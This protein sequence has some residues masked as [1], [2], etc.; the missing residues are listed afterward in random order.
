MATTDQE[1]P[2]L[3]LPARDIPIPTSVSPEAQAAMAMAPLPAPDLPAPTDHGSWRAMIAAQDAA[4]AQM[5]GGRAADAPVVTTELDVR[6][7]HVYEIVPT[8]LAGRDRR[9]YLEIHGGAFVFGG[10]ECCRVMSIGAATRFG[11]RVWAVDYRMPPDHPFPAGLDD[12]LTAYRALLDDHDPAEIIVG[13]ASAGGNLAAALVLLARDEGLPMP[14][15]VVLMTPGVDLTASDDSLQ[16]NLGLDP[17]LPGGSTPTFG[18]YAGDRDLTDPYVSPLFGDFAPGFPP[19]ILT[20]GT[21]DRLLSDTVRMHRALR[22]AGIPADLHVTEAAGH[23]GFLG[24]AP[25]DHEIE[26]ELRLFAESHWP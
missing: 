20:T 22:R 8:D 1:R 13:G 18:M 10:G 14:A 23:G 19:T 12:C 17:L 4:I 3:H 7:A 5:L 25:E 11:T 15:A 21:R 6:G 16:T 2:V 26:R 9:V 24:M